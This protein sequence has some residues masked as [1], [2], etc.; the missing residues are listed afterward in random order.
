LLPSLEQKE[1]LLEDWLA[2]YL[3]PGLGSV[4]A[5]RLAEHFGGPDKVF[6]AGHKALAQISGLRKDA[7]A[8]LGKGPDRRRVARELEKAEK[9]GA[10]IIFRHEDV[11]PEALREIHNPPLVLYVKG[12][13]EIISR[14]GVSIVG[15]RAATVYG[16]RIAMDL[17]TRLSRNELTI[18]SGLA[19]GIDTAAHQ[20]ALA[21]EGKTIAVLGCGLD[22]VYPY[23]NRQLAEKIGNTGALVTEYP[24]G[25]RPEAFRFPARNRIISGL[26]LGVVVVE[27]A[28]RSGS[29]ITAE[30]ALDQGREVFAVPGR[31]DSGKSEGAH[32]LL[33]DGAK[34]V[35][36]VKDILEELCRPVTSRE[37]KIT[38]QKVK[39]KLS[40]EEKGLLAFMDIYP[41]TIDEII[42][43]SKLPAH[44]VNELLLMLELKGLVEVMAGR[45]YQLVPST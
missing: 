13:P 41:Q 28:K 21:A 18:I 37:N 31:I 2:L 5:I 24:F 7:V 12:N 25:T 20:G 14:P 42:Q 34:L 32:R 16:Q 4:W 11:Y 26:A 27:A 39:P 3:T 17:A 29:L 44:Q 38:D 6:R 22:V 10:K 36:T 19:L 43:K 8:A 1:K 15:S 40:A 33:Q 45:Q 30:L 9:F 35:H 23:Q